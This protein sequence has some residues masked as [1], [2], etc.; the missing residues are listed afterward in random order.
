MANAAL[1]QMPVAVLDFQTVLDHRGVALTLS[2]NVYPMAV[3]GV[4]RA[5]ATTRDKTDS[6]EAYQRF[7]QLWGEADQGQPLIVEA[8][9][10]SKAATS[11]H[12]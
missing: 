10:K 12:R 1:G 7:L 5:H 3:L 2:S 6:A 4:A 11:A 8:L 9:A